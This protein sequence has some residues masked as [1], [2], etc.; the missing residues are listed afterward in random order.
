MN[1]EPYRAT[2]D[3]LR[4]IDAGLLDMGGPP[5]P[6]A[7]LP[8]FYR[9]QAVEYR[10][11]ADQAETIEMRIKLLEFAEHLDRLASGKAGAS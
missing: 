8:E 5:I 4:A 1:R 7:E 2:P 10:E 9:T 11:L 6:E 3:E